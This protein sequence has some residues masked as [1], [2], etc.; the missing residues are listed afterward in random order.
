MSLSPAD[1]SS[2]AHSEVAVINDLAALMR[3]ERS[4]IRRF[5][6]D[7]NGTVV[8][9]AADLSAGIVVLNTTEI[10]RKKRHR[11]FA[12]G[13]DQ[14]RGNDGVY[15]NVIPIQA[16]H[17]RPLKRA[18]KMDRS[19]A[20]CGTSRTSSWRRGPDGARTLCNACGLVYLRQCQKAERAGVERTLPVQPCLAPVQR[21]QPMSIT[22]L[23]NP[24]D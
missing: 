24:I 12:A 2:L 6:S 18:S 21:S 10:H 17:A 3:A 23:L 14:H 9:D 1:R 19:C 20:A 7:D 13:E 11:G 8:A 5:G 4:L 16:R 15:M 22:N